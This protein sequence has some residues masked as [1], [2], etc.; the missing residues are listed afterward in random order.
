M[1]G[2]N[3]I[4]FVLFCFHRK[5]L[6][7]QSNKGLNLDSLH[8]L[9]N[10]GLEF[11]WVRNINGP[12][13]QAQI[14]FGEAGVPAS[15]PSDPHRR[16]TRTP[17]PEREGGGMDGSAAELKATSGNQDSLVCKLLQNL[18]FFLNCPSL[19]WG[20]GVRNS[21]TSQ[22]S[23]LG[24]HWSSRRPELGG[25]EPWHQTPAPPS[26][27]R[28]PRPSPYTQV[29]PLRLLPQLLPETVRTAYTAGCLVARMELFCCLTSTPSCRFVYILVAQPV[30]NAFAM[31][32]PR[33]DP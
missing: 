20:S 5:L 10:C 15:S 31:R 4:C 13:E 14:F 12:E 28:P 22:Y 9:R 18:H 33:F 32:R 8:S 6:C 11:S 3:D 2:G 1:G 21:Q 30:K 25:S 17:A 24:C 19:R 29:R 26:S 23:L 16:S 7:L 27:S